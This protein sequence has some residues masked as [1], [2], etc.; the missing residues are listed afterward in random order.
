MVNNI[1]VGFA[2]ETSTVNNKI[3]LEDVQHI[4]IT[5]MRAFGGNMLLFFFDRVY[6]LSDDLSG[7]RVSENKLKG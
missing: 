6:M 3:S 5:N 2:I 4:F 7:F 1:P